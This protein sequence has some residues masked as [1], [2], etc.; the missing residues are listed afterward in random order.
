MKAFLALLQQ[1]RTDTIVA[2]RFFTRLP[3]IT[4]P[5]EQDQTDPSALARALG[6]APLIGI[7]IGILGGVV[8]EVA[9]AHALAGIPAAL[10]ALFIVTVLTGGLHEDGLADTADGLGAGRDRAKALSIMRDSRIGTFGVLA[11]IFSLGLRA[12][13]LSGMPIHEAAM[14][15]IAAAALSR[16]LPAGIV[17]A[18]SPARAD[19]LG[20]IT[21]AAP[22]TAASRSILAALI[23][24]IGAVVA[25]GFVA[26]V[27]SFLLAFAIGIFVAVVARHRLGG[28]TGDVLGAAQQLSEVA[29]LLLCAAV[30]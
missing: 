23:A 14:A 16:A 22:E 20:S 15:F 21:A 30:I 9:S 26:A 12:A 25:I 11:L 28:Y 7:G 17:A 19:G 4:L 5:G 8:I 2:L 3:W 6:M 1:Y 18:L 27:W 10:L 13:A 29:V 24:F